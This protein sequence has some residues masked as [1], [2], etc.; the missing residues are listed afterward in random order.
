M[1]I[2][3]DNICLSI[4]LLRKKKH[5]FCRILILLWRQCLRAALLKH[6]DNLLHPPSHLEL[7]VNLFNH[8]VLVTWLGNIC[9]LDQEIIQSWAINSQKSLSTIKFLLGFSAMWCNYFS[10]FISETAIYSVVLKLIIC[11]AWTSGSSATN[12]SSLAMD[13][14]TIQFSINAWVMSVFC[15]Y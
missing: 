10:C 7:L 14:Q 3:W 1:G 8:V 2:L 6:Q 15:L 12:P 11:C 13:R 9:K 4:Y 5:G